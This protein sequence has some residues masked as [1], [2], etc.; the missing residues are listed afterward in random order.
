M[1]PPKD[2]LDS[3]LD[4][5]E[6]ATP[7]PDHLES[8]VWRRIA[9]NDNPETTNW[10]GRLRAVFSRPSFSIAFAAA[11]VLLGL[12]LFQLHATRQHQQRN[13]QLVQSYL[14]LIDPLLVS[15]TGRASTPASPNLDALLAW[16][17]TDLRL[18][19]D[20]L[21]RVRSVHEQLSP[22]LLLLAEKV[23]GMQQALASFEQA[24][25]T[26]GRIDFLEFATYVEARRRLDQEC[27]ESTRKLIAEASGVMTPQQRQ[28]YLQALNPAI[29]STGGSL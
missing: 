17:K 1:Q 18:T 11:C 5:W 21:A 24:R 4:Q 12:F 15:E 16:M 27:N 23:A 26:A 9:V 7:T 22:H 20:Q 19:D 29:K 8:E 28:L 6:K 2:P 10:L 14:H 3:L 13:L 25:T